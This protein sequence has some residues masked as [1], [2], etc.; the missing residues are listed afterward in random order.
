MANVKG[1]WNKAM[2]EH[3]SP[4]GKR[5]GVSPKKTDSEGGGRGDFADPTNKRYPLN[6]PGRAKAAASYFG[7]P[8]NRDKY[9]PAERGTMDK[10]ISGAEK[11]YGI[12]EK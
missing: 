7:M 4:I 5:E 10:K 8:K 11:K 1:A 9:S 2:K 12:G 3:S 6:T